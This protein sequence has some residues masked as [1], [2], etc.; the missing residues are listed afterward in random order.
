MTTPVRRPSSTIGSAPTSSVFISR[1]A[2]CA[3]VSGVIA[4]GFDVIASCT[5][6]CPMFVPFPRFERDT[7]GSGLK[8]VA[9]LLLAVTLQPGSAAVG[10]EITV[11]GTPARA[12]VL[13]GLETAIRPVPL[14]VVG[15]D[16]TLT[17]EVPDVPAGRYRIVVAGEAEAPVL[18]VVA[19]SRDTSLLLL[20]FGFLL[21]LGFVVAGVVVHRR[22]RD[23][24]S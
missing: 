2:S 19:L 17:A 21:V 20:G 5:V 6:W 11:T 22:W 9:L 10:D 8:T 3:V 15:A 1:A 14:G 18:E 23:A 24:I 4:V 16:G 13:E 7:L 12:V